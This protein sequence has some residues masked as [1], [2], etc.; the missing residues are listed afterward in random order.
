MRTVAGW[1]VSY[2]IQAPADVPE[3]AFPAYFSCLQWALG[4]DEIRAAFEKETGKRYSAA[5][6]TIDLL[7]DDATGWRED[8]VKAFVEWFNANI[9]GEFT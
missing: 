8:Y 4:E 2:Q 3:Y 5:R 6:C 1:L 9:W 7:I